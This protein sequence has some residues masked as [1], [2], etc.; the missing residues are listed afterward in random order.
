[1]CPMEIFRGLVFHRA[2]GD[3]YRAVVD[4]PLIV[5]EFQIAAETAT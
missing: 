1:M 5:G 2:G 4:L 3:H